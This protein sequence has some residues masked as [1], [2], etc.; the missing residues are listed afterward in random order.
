MEGNSISEIPK[1]KQ[2]AD[3]DSGEPWPAQSRTS[4]RAG[5]EPAGRGRGQ[6]PPARRE[7]QQAPSDLQTTRFEI[8][9]F[10]HEFS[11]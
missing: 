6:E 4:G 1:T 7:G 3:A 11:V 5:E 2:V 9:F 8:F 10:F